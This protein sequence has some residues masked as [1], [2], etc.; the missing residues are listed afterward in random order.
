MFRTSL[1][2]QKDYYNLALYVPAAGRKVANAATWQSGA[3]GPM[4]TAKLTMLSEV[5]CSYSA[6]FNSKIL[7]WFAS[8]QWGFL[9]CYAA[10]ANTLWQRIIMLAVL[11]FKNIMY[12]KS[13]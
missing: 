3:L 5:S 10:F 1:L 7:N 12:L 4:L 8:C 2:S 9:V 6:L 11:F 13:I